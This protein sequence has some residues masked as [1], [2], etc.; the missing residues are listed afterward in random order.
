MPLAA[1]TEAQCVGASQVLGD[2]DEIDA[3]M[4]RDA[5]SGGLHTSTARSSA[6][7][8]SCLEVTVWATVALQPNC[9][10]QGLACKAGVM[11]GASCSALSFD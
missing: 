8:S 6:S 10:V 2:G 5:V 9:L 1:E 3:G 11:F 7:M 4:G